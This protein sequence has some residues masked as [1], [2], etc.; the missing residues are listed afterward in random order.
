MAM[1]C[2]LSGCTSENSALKQ[3]ME[4]RARLLEAQGCSFKVRITADYGEDLYTFSV[5]CEGD[6]NGTITFQVSEPEALSGITGKLSDT[7]GI[8]T[9]D[10]TALSFPYLTDDQLNPVSAPWI[11]LKTLR[12]GYLTSACEED[13][14]LR[15]SIDDSYEEDALHLDIWMD[16]DRVPIRVDILYDGKR[17]L[18]LEITD[19]QFL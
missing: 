2:F 13:G 14:N 12:S 10:E 17:I 1:V 16:E 4:I 7:G 8:L 15:L 3:G 6:R 5:G 11:F 19:F 18:S 9:F